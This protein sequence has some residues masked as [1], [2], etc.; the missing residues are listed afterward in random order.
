MC[1]WWGFFNVCVRGRRI[2]SVTN[3]SFDVILD[4]TSSTY[5]NSS[6]QC[7]HHLGNMFPFLIT[8]VNIS[9]LKKNAKFPGN[10]STGV[11][12]TP[13]YLSKLGL[14]KCATRVQLVQ[15]SWCLFLFICTVQIEL[16]F[17][18]RVSPVQ[19]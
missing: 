17:M 2:F 10:H 1:T 5:G 16:Q 3:F 6:S 12:L 8:Q 9:L 15:S 4:L 13:S 19:G 18:A 14:R 7:L 11:I